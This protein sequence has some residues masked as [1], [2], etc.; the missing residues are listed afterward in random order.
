MR[1]RVATVLAGLLVMV[2]AV[3][4]A[5]APAAAGSYFNDYSAVGAPAM[6]TGPFAFTVAVDGPDPVCSMVFNG[7]TL[8][9]PPWQ[10]AADPLTGTYSPVVSVTLCDAT[11]SPYPERFRVPTVVAFSAEGLLLTTS[12]AGG[13]DGEVSISSEYPVDATARAVTADGRTIAEVG[14]PAGARYTT[15]TVPLDRIKSLR[16]GAVVVAAGDG[17]TMRF[18][19]TVAEGWSTIWANPASID[20]ARTFANCSEV[21]WHYSPAGRPAKARTIAKDI[22]KA[23]SLLDARTGLRFREVDT[24]AEATLTFAW[25]DLGRSGPSAVGGPMTSSSGP[26]TG[27]VDINTKDSWPTDRYAGSASGRRPNGGYGP[28]GRVWLLVHE[29]MHTMGFGHVEDD[30]DAIMAP[31]NT[32][33]AAFSRGDLNGLKAMYPISACGGVGGS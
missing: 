19:I 20:S 15:L 18:P 9:A 31:I 10:F 2:A 13:Q 21:T 17:T 1:L 7:V 26:S 5:A 30:R 6:A 32:G 11:E 33:Q 28:S 8:A 29:T 4:G 27:S 12:P 25:K 23:V 22:R 24:A 14:V 3:A 16:G